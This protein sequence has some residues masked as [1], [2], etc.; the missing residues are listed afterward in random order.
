[1]ES[2][3]RMGYGHILKR[4]D[5]KLGGHSSTMGRSVATA[6]PLQAASITVDAARKSGAHQS[7]SQSS[8]PLK[9]LWEPTSPKV[10]AQPKV[11]QESDITIH[12][13]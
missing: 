1:M 7:R 11:S 3:F 5:T 13:T 6:P 2:R 8:P 10:A 9:M 4:A 12:L